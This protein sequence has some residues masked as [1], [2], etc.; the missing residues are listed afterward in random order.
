METVQLLAWLFGIAL[1]LY[2]FASLRIVIEV[3]MPEG[4][5]SHSRSPATSL[6]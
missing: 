6:S 4:L 2:S 3:L 1:V 5:D